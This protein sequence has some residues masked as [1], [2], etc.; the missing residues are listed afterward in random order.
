MPLQ[1]VTHTLPHPVNLKPTAERP[2]RLVARDLLRDQVLAPHSHPYGQVT[3]A[4]EGVCQVFADYS[5]WFVPPLRAIWVPPNMVHEVRI[6]QDARLRALHSHPGTVPLP[7]THC[8]VLEVSPLLRELILAME[9]ENAPGP[10][11]DRLVHVIRDELQHAESLPMK[12]ALP[13][14]K[15]LK[16]LCAKLMEDPSSDLTLEEHAKQ[17]GA[18]ARTLSRLFEQELGLS[19]GQWRQHLRLAKATSMIANGMPLSR[20]ASELG[21]ASQSAFSAMFK[22]TLG[23]SPSAFFQEP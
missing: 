10:R 8:V 5:T 23:K 18:S 17:A 3:Y 21:Y 12:V 4:R 14:D 1:P 20:V 16:S 9:M 15:R 6:L 22:K 2:L 19:F 7:E 11:E 13:G